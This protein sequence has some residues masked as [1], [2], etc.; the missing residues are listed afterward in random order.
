MKSSNKIELIFAVNTG[1]FHYTPF[2]DPTLGNEEEQRRTKKNEEERRRTKK[3][4]EERRRTTKVTQLLKLH[5]L[6]FAT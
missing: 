1:S 2:P 4:E 3:N 5:Y 6:E